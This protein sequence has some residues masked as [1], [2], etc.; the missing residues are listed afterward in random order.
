MTDTHV[1]HKNHN[2][3]QHRITCMHMYVEHAMYWG[4]SNKKHKHTHT[5]TQ[6]QRRKGGEV[7]G[8]GGWVGSPRRRRWSSAQVLTCTRRHCSAVSLSW[9]FV[10]IAPGRNQPYRWLRGARSVVRLRTIANYRGFRLVSLIECVSVCMEWVFRCNGVSYQVQHS[11]MNVGARD[12]DRCLWWW[13]HPAKILAWI[14]NGTYSVIIRLYNL[15]MIVNETFFALC[16][17]FS[18]VYV[19]VCSCLS[20]FMNSSIDIMIIKVC[21]SCVCVLYKYITVLCDVSLWSRRIF[22]SFMEYY[23]RTT[24]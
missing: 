6:R 20:F 5:A 4:T 23:C 10:S 14:F 11:H 2:I 3:A 16:W 21:V 19:C 15:D 13:S 8:G 24:K 7:E 9:D 17:L 22:F 18:F 1:P 12:R